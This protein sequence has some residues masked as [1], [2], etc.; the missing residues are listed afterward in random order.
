MTFNENHP[1][2]AGIYARL[3]VDS[4]NAKNESIET[5]IDIGKEFIRTHN[6]RIGENQREIQLYQCY[7]DLGKSGTNFQREGFQQMMA[8]I[9]SH[10]VNCVIV[11]DFSR[12]GRDYLETGN[13][14]EKIFPLLGVR[15]ISVTDDFDSL[16]PQEEQEQLGVQLKNLVNDMYAKDIAFRVKTAKKIRRDQGSYVGGTPPYGYTL[17]REKGQRL[18]VPDPE[19]AP[20]VQEIFKSYDKDKNS[21]KI[22]R[23]LYERGIHRP[24]EARQYGHAYAQ[25]GEILQEWDYGSL[26]FLLQNPIYA[27]EGDKSPVSQSLLKR[28][29]F[30]TIQRHFQENAQRFRPQKRE[31]QKSLFLFCGTCG[32]SMERVSSRGGGTFHCRNGG[33]I[34][35]LGCKHKYISQKELEAIFCTIFIVEN[36]LEG[37]TQKD[38]KICYDKEKERQR[39]KWKKELS[40]LEKKE[41]TILQLIAQQYEKYKKGELTKEEFTTCKIDRDKE[42]KQLQ[43]PKTSLEIKLRQSICTTDQPW[44]GKWQTGMSQMIVFFVKKICVYDRGRIEIYFHFARQKR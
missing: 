33:R 14:I 20:I 42:R 19:T 1:F 10:K 24:K 34:D 7:R 43:T 26:K 4:H 32:C 12:F 13:Y 36:W 27:D 15:F 29:H 16:Q 25:R 3:S 28:E 38:W 6:E 2:F 11:K 22:I 39:F 23:Q 5:Q 37:I 41:Q 18:L 21:R 9:R 8:D 30:E 17:I 35:Q 44:C 31:K 40:I